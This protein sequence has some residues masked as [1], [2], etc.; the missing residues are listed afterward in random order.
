MSNVETLKTEDNATLLERLFNQLNA[1]GMKG[2]YGSVW[3]VIIRDYCRNSVK[4]YKYEYPKSFFEA[5]K[6]NEEVNIYARTK[7][8]HVALT[9]FALEKLMSGDIDIYLYHFTMYLI[10]GDYR[11]VEKMKE[12][13]TEAALGKKK[14]QY[15]KEL[16]IPHYMSTDDFITAVWSYQVKQWYVGDNEYQQAPLM[17]D[18]RLLFSHEQYSDWMGTDY[19]NA[20]W[21][22]PISNDIHLKCKTWTKETD[23]MAP[24]ELP[25][26]YIEGPIILGHSGSAS[27]YRHF[28]NGHPVHAGAGIQVKF[29]K[30]WIDGRYEWSFSDKKD[31]IQVHAGD[32]VIYIN[33]GHLVRIRK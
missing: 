13:L 3:P 8:E 18:V 5:I 7:K 27:G 30:G 28:V 1:N 19:Y 17:K 6:R 32:E 24:A 10:F 15:F 16:P 12:E 31:P 29:G 26:G 20:D 4:N 14:A 9:K 33:E 22:E 23:P 11:H 21:V 2:R 25:E